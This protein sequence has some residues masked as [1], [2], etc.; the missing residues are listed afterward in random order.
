MPLK[1]FIC[2]DGGKIDIDQCLNHR[3]CRLHN[4]CASRNY[5]RAVSF[6]RKFTGIIT[7]SAAG[8]G[9][10]HEYLKGTTDYDVAPSGRVW[11]IFGTDAHAVLGREE[12]TVDV[13]SEEKTDAGTPDTLDIDEFFVMCPKCKGVERWDVKVCPWCEVEMVESYVLYDLKT[14]G[15]YPVSLILGFKKETETLTDKD[16][17]PL[18]YGKTAKKAG[19][20]KTRQIIVKGKPKEKYE[21]VLQLN[22]YRMEYEK[23]GFPISRIEITVTPRDG[24]TYVALGRGVT[25][26]L[27]RIPIRRLPD[28]EVTDYY[29]NLQASLDH[30]LDNDGEC[31]PCT[32]WE[33]W[34]GRRCDG[35]CDVADACRKEYNRPDKFKGLEE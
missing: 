3:G 19:Q 18:R 15:S 32:P 31:R 17:K 28:K 8:N 4:R 23:I 29:D 5:L 16:G 11:A 35:Y 9:P 27:Y 33:C 30:A 6:D 14:Y 1:R 13:I 10:A 2:P 26:N 34:N 25:E 21:A 22:R 20:V 12:N 7:A 24:G